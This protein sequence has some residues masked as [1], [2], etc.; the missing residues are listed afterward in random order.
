M[1]KHSVAHFQ[2]CWL[3]DDRYKAW[4]KRATIDTKATCKWCNSDIPIASIGAP[5]LDS[6]SKSKKHASIAKLCLDLNDL[7]RSMFPDST[8]AQKF[9]LSKTKCAYLINFGLGVYY[10][11]L[12]ISEVKE[13][14]FFTLC[15]DESL[16]PVLQNCQMNCGV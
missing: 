11:K 6:H 5:A 14:P 1:P 15:F 16:N 9:K 7:F 4:I 2:E 8:V 13:S 3:T 12:L 10:H